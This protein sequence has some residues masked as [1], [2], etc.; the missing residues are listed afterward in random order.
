MRFESPYNIYCWS[1]TIKYVICFRRSG[2]PS[3]RYVLLKSYSNEGLTFFTNYGSRKAQELAANPK[4][5]ANL[6]WFPLKKQVRIEGTV[7]KVSRAESE[8]YFY[9]RPVDSQIGALAS[10][11]SRVI[12]SRAVLD[13]REAQIRAQLK[14]TGDGVKVPMPNWG[15]YLIEPHRFEFWQGQSNRLHDRIVF[16]RPQSDGGTEPSSADAAM[17]KVGDN[18]WLYERLA[19]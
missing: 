5:C 3:S 10:E 6:Y 12:A 11:Q 2:Q 14:P 8:A 9:E 7:V 18:G 13:E 19:P 15:G 16:R 17:A 1:L 4:I